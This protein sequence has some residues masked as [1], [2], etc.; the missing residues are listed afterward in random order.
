MKNL[1]QRD[2][3]IMELRQEV[4][5][6]KATAARARALIETD[7]EGNLHASNIT[8]ITSQQEQE[9]TMSSSA[10]SR[11]LSIVFKV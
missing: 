1:A 3:M 2:S 7:S 10:V 11:S 9:R 4:E 8:K 5:D 6:L